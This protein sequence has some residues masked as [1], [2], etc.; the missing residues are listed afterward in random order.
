V[1]IEQYRPW[2]WLRS[3]FGRLNTIIGMANIARLNWL[4]RRTARQIDSDGYDVVLAHPCQF[5]QAPLP[6]RWLRSPSLYYC[7]ELPRLLYEPSI[8]RP[9]S[10][11]SLLQRAMNRLDPLPAICLAYYRAVDRAAARQASHIAV[12]SMFTAANV[13][14]TYGTAATV[15]YLGVDSGQFKPGCSR[16]RVVLS[17]GSLTPTKGFDFV[18]EAVATMPPDRRPPLV[19][20]SNAAFPPERAFLEQLAADRQVQLSCLLNIP[21]AELQH[22][23]ARAGC[24]AYAPIREPFGLVALEAMAAGAPLVAVAE[25]GVSETVIDGQT[26]LLAPR[27][28]AQFGQAILQVLEHPEAAELRSL[29]ARAHVRERWTWAQH[30]EQLEQL[31]LSV[32][33]GETGLLR[34]VAA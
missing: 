12:N 13:R 33:Q 11:H 27:D 24:V 18:I 34:T 19:L 26:A 3:P 29:Q 31:L 16:E 32:A 22:W 7:Q 23:Y 17:V 8:G 9:Y 30:I 25:G 5:A 20:I 1:T 15:C 2:P 14:R 21:E 4:A 10:N 6:L 28:P